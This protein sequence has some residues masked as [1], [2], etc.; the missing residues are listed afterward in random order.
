MVNKLMSKARMTDA[1]PKS[2]RS[3]GGMDEDRRYRAEQALSTMTAAEGH[4][5]DKR[6]MADV[7]KV[8][9]EKKQSID[10][11]LGG[12]VKRTGGKGR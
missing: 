7:V 12:V 1:V 8:A 6:L 4:K 9:A 11:A 3:V 5:R 2:S 10:Q